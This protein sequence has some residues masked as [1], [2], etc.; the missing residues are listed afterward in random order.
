MDEYYRSCEPVNAVGNPAANHRFNSSDLLETPCKRIHTEANTNIRD[1]S[2]GSFGMVS[3]GCASASAVASKAEATIAFA[4]SAKKPA[5]VK[6]MPPLSNESASHASS[7]VSV[8]QDQQLRQNATKNNTIIS[9]YNKT[10]NQVPY[11]VNPGRA[12]L[13]P[14]AKQL[15]RVLNPP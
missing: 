3:A 11:R 15:P 7:I 12:G 5:M 8:N 1:D 2:V 6:K 14:C 13:P 4:S 10:T 9:P